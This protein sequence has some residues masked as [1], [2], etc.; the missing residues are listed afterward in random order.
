MLGARE[1]DRQPLPLQ[2]SQCRR[3][4]D[5]NDECIVKMAVQ[6]LKQGGKHVSKDS[7]WP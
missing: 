4:S 5:L 7:G 2:S 1:H 3:G 6:L